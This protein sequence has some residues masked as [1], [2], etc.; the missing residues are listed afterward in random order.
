MKSLLVLTWGAAL[1]APINSEATL[2]TYAPIKQGWYINRQGVNLAGN[3]NYIAGVSQ[4]N[5]FR[6][7]FVFDLSSA[8][9]GGG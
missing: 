4:G 7:W 8:P 3:S 5:W 6:D 9:A 1:L 2:Y